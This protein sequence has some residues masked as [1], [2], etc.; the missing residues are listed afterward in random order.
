[1]KKNLTVNAKQA[2]RPLIYGR[3][4]LEAFGINLKRMAAVSLIL[5][6]ARWALQ[7]KFPAL[8]HPA[9]PSAPEWIR[10]ITLFSMSFSQPLLVRHSAIL[11]RQSGLEN[12]AG[13]MLSAGCFT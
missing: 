8:K 9:A 13:L 10:L 2:K 7:G 12:G 3:W 5:E 4:S 6:S 11:L 1:M